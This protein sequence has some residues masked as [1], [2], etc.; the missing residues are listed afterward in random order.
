M[1]KRQPSI[2]GRLSRGFAFTIAMSL[3]IAIAGVVQIER[4]STQLQRIVNIHSARGDAAAQLLSEIGIIASRSYMVTLLINPKD[5]NT[6]IASFTAAVG[7]YERA[8]ASLA[9]SMKTAAATPEEGRLLAAIQVAAKSGLDLYRQAAKV[10]TE[11]T[12]EATT[13][14]SDKARP[15]ELAWRERISELVTLQARLKHDAYEQAEGMKTAAIAVMTA[16]AV[17]SVV[18]GAL[19]A[20]RATRGVTVP[21]A[22]A[23]ALTERVAAGDLSTS[24]DVRGDRE[25]SRLLQALSDMQRS[26]GQVVREVHGATE[27]IGNASTEIASGNIDLSQRTERAAASL[28]ETASSL[29]QLNGVVQETAESASKA[30]S[31]ATAA[32]GVAGR[33]GAVMGSVGSTMD[34]ITASSQRIAE[35]I[36]VID[37]IAF[38]TNILALNAAVEAARAGEQGRGFAVV[39]GEVRTL[40]QR[41]GEAAKEIRSLI[42]SNVE[43]VAS[44]SQ[45]VQQASSTMQEIV[46][47]VDR[48]NT[49]IAEISAAT[50]RQREDIG[51]VNQAIVQLDSVTQQNAALVEQST[52]AAASLEDQAKGLRQVVAAFRFAEAAQP[53]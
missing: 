19:F 4:L 52:A 44:G 40:A 26:L 22:R 41:S 53:A 42:G 17:A 15:A 27:N 38:Q 8:E 5:M 47:S 45:L 46:T 29:Q 12:T 2:A 11:N 10:G 16:C 51:Q 36:G 14:L 7:R 18:I 32:A 49:V 3:V 30:H 34:E 33:G 37:G 1:F 39:A 9:Q 48:V 35:I 25:V 21:M 23:V 43:R 28:Q 13:L 20:W 50:E 6:E 31:L 24:I